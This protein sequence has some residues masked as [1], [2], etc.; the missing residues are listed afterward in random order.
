M[1]DIVSIL[2]SKPAFSALYN[3][4]GYGSGVNIGALSVTIPIDHVQDYN[5]MV[6]QMQKDPKFEKL[7][8]AM[9][10]DRAVGRSRLSKNRIQF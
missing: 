2:R 7:V 1:L 4:T 9:T 6:S 5:E 3:N 8:N 10:L